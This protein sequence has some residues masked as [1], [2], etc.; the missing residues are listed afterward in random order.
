[1]KITDSSGNS[2]QTWTQH[3]VGPILG[4]GP[5]EQRTLCL[6]LIDFVTR[7]ESKFVCNNQLNYIVRSNVIYEKVMLDSHI[8]GC[9]KDKVDFGM[10]QFY[11]Y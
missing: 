9:K 11:H 1:M 3:Y 8:S 5:I 6:A 4:L 7:E 2:I 10:A